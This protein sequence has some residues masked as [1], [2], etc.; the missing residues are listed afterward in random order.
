MLEKDPE[1]RI[2]INEILEHD[3]LLSVV[4]TSNPQVAVDPGLLP[5]TVNNSST[6]STFLPK[7]VL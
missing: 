3:W 4:T 7:K 1:K 5:V 2:T 6:I